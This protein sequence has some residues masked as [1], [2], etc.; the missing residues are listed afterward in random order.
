MGQAP[1]CNVSTVSRPSSATLFVL[2]PFAE[3]AHCI[4][5]D[6]TPSA[7]PRAANAAPSPGEDGDTTL[8]SPTPAPPLRSSRTPIKSLGAI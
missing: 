5:T 8:Y 1:L 6:Q 2:L 4:P 7:E 3:F